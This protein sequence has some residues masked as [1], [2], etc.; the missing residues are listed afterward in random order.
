[1]IDGLKKTVLLVLLMGIV[2]LSYHCGSGSLE[3]V[4]PEMKGEWGTS[5]PKFE[6]FS[7]EISDKSLVFIDKNAEDPFEI[8]P[9]SRIEKD[10]EEPNLYIIHYKT[11]D[12]GDYK[13]SFYFDPSDGG[14]IT[15][16]NQRKY[17]WKRIKE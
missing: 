5:A 12:S 10:K 1:M 15:L 11:E 2:V 13:F 8:Y 16:K 14:I 6:G 9:I 7:F 4:P 17:I 3:A